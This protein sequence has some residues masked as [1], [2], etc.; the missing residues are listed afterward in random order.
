MNAFHSAFTD[1]MLTCPLLPAGLGIFQSDYDYDIIRCM[2][3][4]IGLQDI[5]QEDAR[6]TGKIDVLA[7]G[8]LVQKMG[9]KTSGELRELDHAHVDLTPRRPGV[10][11]Y[12]LYAG[13]CSDRVR[14]RDDVSGSVIK[15]TCKQ[16]IKDTKNPEWADH[17]WRAGYMA[18]LLGACFMSLGCTIPTYFLSFMRMTYEDEKVGL[19]RDART[20]I[21]KALFGPD[22][23]VNGKPYD[24]GS[25]G[26][27]ATVDAGGAPKEDRLYDDG[28]IN[29]PSPDG[30]TPEKIKARELA[31]PKGEP[32]GNM[33]QKEPSRKAYAS[34]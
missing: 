29:V 32:Y 21:R 18:V 1:I 16:L 7:T 10:V 31:D 17:E 19:M 25:K 33:A 26:L 4:A 15:F 12:S 3:N 2:S 6:K 23:F 9:G 30:D 8:Y 34:M 14:V 11:Y 22:G 27:R 24:F 13:L 20:Q 5:E 28:T